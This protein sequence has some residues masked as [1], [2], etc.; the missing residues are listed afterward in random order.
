MVAALHVSRHDI[1]VGS[2]KEKLPQQLD[3]LTLGDVRVREDEDIV[4]F[5]EEK[6]KIG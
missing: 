4:I 6:S 5:G 3:A 2:I 1:V